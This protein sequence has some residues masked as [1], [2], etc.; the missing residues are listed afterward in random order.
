MHVIPAFFTSKTPNIPAQN[1]EIFKAI[2][3]KKISGEKGDTVAVPLL[4][5]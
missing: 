3:H 2:H 5:G 4:T 1:R